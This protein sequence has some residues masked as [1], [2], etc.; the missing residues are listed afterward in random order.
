MVPQVLLLTQ[1]VSL[2]GVGEGWGQMPAIGENSQVI[3][4]CNPIWELMMLMTGVWW[5]PVKRLQIEAVSNVIRG[6][7]MNMAEEQSP[8]QSWRGRTRPQIFRDQEVGQAHPSDLSTNEL[9]PEAIR[10]L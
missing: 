3:P 2:L 5:G 7:Y 6:L 8:A 10:T 9:G 4:M 1:E